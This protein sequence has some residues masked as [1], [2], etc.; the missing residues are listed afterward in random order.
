MI[1]ENINKKGLTLVELLVVIAI[2]GI[3]AGVVLVSISSLRKKARRSSA[4]QTV[5]S[6][7][8][9]IEEC[10]LKGSFSGTVS[11]SFNSGE[12]PCSGSDFPAPQ[13]SFPCDPKHEGNKEWQIHFDGHPSYPGEVWLECGESDGFGVSCKYS[14]T[15]I[16][17][18]YDRNY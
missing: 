10:Y 14:G 1:S 2:I 12:K 4:T 15:E 6:F 5:E 3:L 16:G 8:P 11:Y 7:L 13:T 9:A 18:C 17:Q